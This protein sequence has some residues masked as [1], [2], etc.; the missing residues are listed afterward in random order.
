LAKNPAVLIADADHAC[1]GTVAGLLENVG[2]RPLIA[3]H[4]EAALRVAREK[5]P[6]VALL[7]V[8]L[9]DMNG[10]ELCRALRDELGGSTA[11]ALVSGTRT[12]P[13][14]VSSGLL[15]GADDYLVKPFDPNVLLA[16]VHA[17]ARRVAPNGAGPPAAGLTRRELEILRMLADGRDQAEI[18][19]AL[20]V[21][22]RTVG[23]HIEHILGKLGVHSRAQAVAAAY[24]LRLF[25]LEAG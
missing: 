2:Y 20:S 14:D 16:R 4:G 11:I 17:L 7:E 1:V 12:S 22:P 10:F 6:E 5:R 18:A 24:R 15:I 8:E 21:S 13:I 23:G 3:T 9:P 19:R 25:D